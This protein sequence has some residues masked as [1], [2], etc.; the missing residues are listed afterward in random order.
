MTT[1]DLLITGMILA[2]ILASGYGVYHAIQ[3]WRLTHPKHGRSQEPA[4]HPTCCCGV[5]AVL[6][7][8]WDAYYC[9]ASGYWLEPNCNDQH[10]YICPNRPEKCNG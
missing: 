1:I 10:C 7:E 5:Q 2:G 8:K 4:R 9:P 6:S 3:F